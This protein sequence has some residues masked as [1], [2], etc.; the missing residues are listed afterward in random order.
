M[1]KGEKCNQ[2]H[3][4]HPLVCATRKI[5]GIIK[6][7]SAPEAVAAANG[8]EGGVHISIVLKEPYKKLIPFKIFVSLKFKVD[9]LALTLAK[10]QIM[11]IYIT[12]SSMKV[13]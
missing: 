10:W 4:L 13:D 9:S 5:A 2:K 11:N 6:S 3:I 7:I 1:F 8:V 12:E